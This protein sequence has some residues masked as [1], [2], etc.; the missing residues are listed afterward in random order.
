MKNRILYF[1][2]AF[3]FVLLIVPGSS[4]KSQSSVSYNFRYESGQ[5]FA[6]ST[7]GSI[8]IKVINTGS[9]V[10]NLRAIIYEDFNPRI[11][12]ADSGNVTVSPGQNNGISY[13]IPPAT[14]SDFSAEIFSDS[15]D[16]VVAIT[17]QPPCSVVPCV[18]PR[19]EIQHGQL[20]KYINGFQF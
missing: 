13:S 16:L 9:A 4:V 19:V 12:R 11:S 15:T 10:H 20:A 14:A 5:F 2:V 18:P 1:A 8:G 7:D 17:I 3:F 6:Q